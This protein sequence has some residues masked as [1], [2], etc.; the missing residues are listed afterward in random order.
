VGA[1]EQAAALLARDPAAHT[2]LDDPHSV[3]ALLDRLR[4]V[5]AGEQAAALPA[6]D[7]EIARAH[8]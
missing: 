8:A 2:A 4:K 7:P 5:G 3:V 6:R 1:G